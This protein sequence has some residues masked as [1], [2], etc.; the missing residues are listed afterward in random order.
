MEP[1]HPDERKVQDIDLPHIPCA[2]RTETTTGPSLL[3]TH[4]SN[5]RRPRLIREAP[6][7][8][9][10]WRMSKVHRSRRLG[11][12]TFRNGYTPRLSGIAL[13]PRVRRCRHDP[14]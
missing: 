9:R 13:K 2:C 10:P 4:R 12:K 8:E 1:H 3:A 6:Q 7:F 5:L 11:H 14:G